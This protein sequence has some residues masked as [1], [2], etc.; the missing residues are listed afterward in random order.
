MKR[1]YNNIQTHLKIS[2]LHLKNSLKTI[3]LVLVFFNSNLSFAQNVNYE[4]AKNLGGGGFDYARSVTTDPFGNVYAT[5]AFQN[6]V[7]FDPGSGTT[8]L[9]SNGG[10]DVFVSKFDAAGNFVWARGFGGTGF[11]GAY[12]LHTDGAGNIYVGGQFQQTADF[13]P[14][15]GTNT[16]TSN[17]NS[18]AFISKFDTS[19]N[20]I[21]ARGFGGVGTD[22]VNSLKTDLAGNLLIT[23]AF[24]STVDFDPGTG[25]SNLISNGDKDVYISKFDPSGSFIWAKSFGGTGT[26]EGSSV[27]TDATGNIYAG[28]LFSSTVDF[29]PGAGTSNSTSAGGTDIFISKLDASGNFV[30]TKS[31]GSTLNDAAESLVLDPTG[32]VYSTGYFEGIV[33]FD[34]GAGSSN[35]TSNGG[36]DVFVSKLDASGNYI[37]AKA[38]GASSGDNGNSINIDA[39]GNIH[40]AGSYRDAVD[41]DPGTGITNLSSNGSDD[42]FIS[43]FDPFGNFMW[44]KS[45]GGSLNDFGFSVHVDASGNVLVSGNFYSTVDFD[46]GA[47]TSNLSSN[48]QLDAFILKLACAPSTG[49]ETVTACNSYDFN[50][51]TYTA[52]NMTAT[53][54]LMSAT[55][56][57]SIITLNL[58]I[59]T[60]DNTTSL[61]GIT[62]SSNAVGVDYQWIDCNNGNIAI[63]GATNASYTPPVNGSYAVV[64]SNVSCTD[65]SACVNLVVDGT[66][67]ENSTLTANVK[68]FPN[69]TTGDITIDLGDLNNV[70]I[71][72]MSSLGVEVFRIK[73]LSMSKLQV[74][75]AEFSEGI[76]FVQIQHGDEILTKKMVKH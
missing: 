12:V 11:E 7:D 47:G 33:D 17:G 28:G 56:C 13:D 6:T 39:V 4:W 53:D 75:L 30:W 18:D 41:F 3:V 57:D 26:D 70:N 27:S 48:G 43:K 46:P 65:T 69:P 60:I 16:L 50:G 64:V 20:F 2:A 55:G 36:R 52:D 49:T 68:L 72:I 32:N 73:N 15:S 66:G 19:G 74:S 24:S 14:G 35:L 71:S 67:I 40:V 58:T 9:T 76:Y 25:T 22:D 59:N 51:I 34:P 8:A 21:W 61:A 62:I 29:D 1:Y 5:G 63:S 31:S 44:A 54:T 42:I 45:C 23:G 38:F 37:W 10:S